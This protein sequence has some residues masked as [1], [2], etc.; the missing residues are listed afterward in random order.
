MYPSEISRLSG[1]DAPTEI[2]RHHA[3]LAYGR[4]AGNLDIDR[5]P[6]RST[7]SPSSMIVE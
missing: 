3:A 5:D 4:A 7:L 2:E 1:A 6:Q